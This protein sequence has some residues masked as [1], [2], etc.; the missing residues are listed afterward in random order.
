MCVCNLIDQELVAYHCIGRLVQTSKPQSQLHKLTCAVVY[1]RDT[2]H[3]I[4]GSKT[5]AFEPGLARLVLLGTNML[6]ADV[7]IPVGKHP[8]SWLRRAGYA[9][10][11]EFMSLDKFLPVT[12]VA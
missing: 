5:I 8:S 2:R 7:S 3:A 10:E 9:T 4:T 1:E 6:T 11:K 12:L